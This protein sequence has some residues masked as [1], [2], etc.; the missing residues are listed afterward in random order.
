MA[1]KDE[2]GNYCL[3]YAGITFGLGGLITLIGFVF[4]GRDFAGKMDID[5]LRA[6]FFVLVIAVIISLYSYLNKNK[7]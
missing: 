4:N 3:V 7:D 1:K 2:G 5:G 6:A